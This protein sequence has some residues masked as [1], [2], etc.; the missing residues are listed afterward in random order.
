MQKY[1][2]VTLQSSSMQELYM[3]TEVF[4]SAEIPN[5]I[6]VKLPDGL[7][8]DMQLSSIYNLDSNKTIEYEGHV[9]R[10][11]NRPW[12]DIDSSIL[13]ITAGQHVYRLI[14][15]KDGIILNATCWFSYVIQDNFVPKPYIY[16]DRS[17][18]EDTAE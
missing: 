18:S 14:F 5:V 10:D 17:E 7:P 8:R 1:F 15:S 6:C 2:T 12:I 9:T 13:D 11:E 4:N 16:M 3:H